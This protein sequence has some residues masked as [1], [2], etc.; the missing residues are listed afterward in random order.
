M[1]Q[2]I[3]IVHAYRRARQIMQ[4]RRWADPAGP[5]ISVLRDQVFITDT[6]FL[7][8]HLVTRIPAALRA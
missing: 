2:Q 4:P 8:D 1:T 5:R 3:A 6:G 7:P